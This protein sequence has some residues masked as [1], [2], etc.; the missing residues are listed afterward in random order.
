MLITPDFTS[1]L[2]LKVIFSALLISL[3]TFSL[4]FATSCQ[5]SPSPE[6]PAPESTLPT[7][8]E[9]PESNPP[10][11]GTEVAIVGFAFKAATLTVPIGTTVTWTNQDSAPHTV[12]AREGLF[13]GGTLSRN[14]TFS[15][16]FTE[17]GTF[18][19]Y[20]KIHPYMTGTII[21]E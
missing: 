6:A 13:D 9:E 18:E 12:T 4:L 21:V 8:Q 7:G 11:A 14:D 17:K 3:L 19:H 5:T 15:Y 2:T 16:T 1:R 20:C 10:E